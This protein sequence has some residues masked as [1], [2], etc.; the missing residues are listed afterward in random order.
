MWT[1]TARAV[2]STYR[3]GRA[4]RGGLDLG[5]AD[6]AL[7]AVAGEGGYL[8]ASEAVHELAQARVVGAI[9]L[10]LDP[11]R[12]GDYGGFEAGVGAHYDVPLFAVEAQGLDRAGGQVGAVGDPDHPVVHAV[13]GVPVLYGPLVGATV[14]PQGVV[15]AVGRRAAVVLYGPF[16]ELVGG[17][18]VDL[19]ALGWVLGQGPRRVGPLA[20]GGE[21]VLDLLHAHLRLGELRGLAGLRLRNR[22]LLHPPG[23]RRLG[24]GRPGRRLLLGAIVGRPL[25]ARRCLPAAGSGEDHEGARQEDAGGTPHPSRVLGVQDLYPS[26]PFRQGFLRTGRYNGSTRKGCEREHRPPGGSDRRTG[27]DAPDGLAGDSRTPPHR[28]RRGFAGQP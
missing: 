26:V 24:G 9:E 15:L 18:G 7:A 6:A 16:R 23:L 3:T 22:R 20:V 4:L 28:L 11:P 5:V 8:R 17:G 27:P 21:H 19:D 13:D 12:G 2:G 14:L 25:R 1:T 10:E